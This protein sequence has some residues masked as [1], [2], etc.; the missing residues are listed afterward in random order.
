MDLDQCLSFICL[1]VIVKL[2]TRVQKLG[3]S[4]AC[5]LLHKQGN[6]SIIKPKL[7]QGLMNLH[8]GMITVQAVSK[9]GKH[10]GRPYTKQTIVQQLQQ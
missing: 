8:S 7:E 1:E 4:A 5:C 6:F 9:N 3:M 2:P 10:F